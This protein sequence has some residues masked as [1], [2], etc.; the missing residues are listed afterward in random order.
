MRKTHRDKSGNYF[1]YQDR[2]ETLNYQVDW[3]AWL[4]GD[5]ISSASYV[6]RNV[7]LESSNNTTT[8]TE[9]Y[10]TGTNGYVVT[11]ITTA[12]GLVKQ[13]TLTFREKEA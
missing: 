11:T 6:A 9:V 10:V 13:M 2:D 8:A 12:L 1:V 3:T 4:N 7:T 5:T